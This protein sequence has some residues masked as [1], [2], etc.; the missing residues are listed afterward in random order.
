MEH[1]E[2]AYH[3]HDDRPP[4][5]GIVSRYRNL[6]HHYHHH[7]GA[8]DAGTFWAGLGAVRAKVFAE[9]D[10]FDEWRYERPQIEDIELGRRIV[11]NGYRI[12][13]D[14]TIQGAHLKRWTLRDVLRTDWKLS[15][16]LRRHR[17]RH[18][19]PRDVPLGPVCSIDP[20]IETSDPGGQPLELPVESYLFRSELNPLGRI[21]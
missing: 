18:H 2:R 9:V 14:P 21:G 11:R 19:A 17:S 12:L 8:G 10:K 7:L 6:L 16:V 13:L 1:G 20:P 5:S 3:S 4:A 15:F